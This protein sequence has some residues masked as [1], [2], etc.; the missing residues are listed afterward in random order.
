MGRKDLFL[1]AVKFK[2]PLRRK[3]STTLRGGLDKVIARV[4]NYSVMAKYDTMRK[5]ERNQA[6]REYA[7]SH[8]DA[9]LKEIGEIFNIDP[10]RVWRILHNNRKRGEEVRATNKSENK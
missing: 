5:L 4:Y 3:F 8:P 6:L 1:Q 9:S 10:S 7:A 2:R